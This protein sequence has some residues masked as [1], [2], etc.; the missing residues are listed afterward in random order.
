MLT[1]QLKGDLLEPPQTL[2]G[3]PL[4]CTQPG[5]PPKVS[6]SNMEYI[7]EYIEYLH[8][9]SMCCHPPCQFITTESLYTQCIPNVLHIGENTNTAVGY[10]VSK[11]TNSM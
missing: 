6:G 8:H 5:P 10:F 1:C 11:I 9:N 3:A 7:L 2:L 4:H